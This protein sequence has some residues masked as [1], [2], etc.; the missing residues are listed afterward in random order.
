MDPSL[1]W[2][3]GEIVEVDVTAV[4]GETLIGAPL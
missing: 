1:R 4:E 3:D 2:G